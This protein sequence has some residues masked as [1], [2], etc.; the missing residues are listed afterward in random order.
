MITL[1]GLQMLIKSLFKFIFPEPIITMPSASSVLQK[2]KRSKRAGETGRPPLSLAP[3]GLRKGSPRLCLP[4]APCL[5]AEAGPKDQAHL[6]V[7]RK[8][9]ARGRT[10]VFYGMRHY[11]KSF[12]LSY[13]VKEVVNPYIKD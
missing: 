7:T 8:A 6:P 2:A 12:L 4:A 3:A 13:L 10:D 1:I 5:P 9:G 11:A